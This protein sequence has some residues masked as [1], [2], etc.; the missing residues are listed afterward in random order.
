[1]LQSRAW[2]EAGNVQPTRP[3]IVAQR[4][5]A[6]RVPAVTGFPSQHFNGPTSWAVDTGGSV[7]HVYA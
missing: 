3:Q 4:G 7:R 2:D 5:Q 6:A 1:V